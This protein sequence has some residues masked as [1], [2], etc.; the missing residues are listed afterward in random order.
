MT[1]TEGKAQRPQLANTVEILDI[2]T[3]FPHRQLFR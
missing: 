3:A 2:G 1:A